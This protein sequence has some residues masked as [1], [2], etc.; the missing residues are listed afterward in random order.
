[1]TTGTSVIYCDS[2]I[3]IAYFNAEVGRVDNITQL[4]DTVASTDKEI[5]ATS[6]LTI[7]EVARFASEKLTGTMLDESE[8]K[9]DQFWQNTDLIRTVDVSLAIARQARGLIRSAAKLNYSLKTPDALHLA[10][11]QEIG[12]DRFLTYDALGRYESLTR[13]K[14]TTP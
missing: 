4:F 12:A 1:M 10:T 7:T 5:L 9:L 11:A 8:K 2:N 6:V 3:F 14:I 13:F